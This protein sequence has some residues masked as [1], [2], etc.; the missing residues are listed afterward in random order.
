[1]SNIDQQ[2]DLAKTELKLCQSQMDKYDDISTKIKTWSVTVWLTS[3]GW[4]I[5]SGKKEIFLLN[6]LAIIFFWSLDAANKNYRT[7]YKK[8]RNEIASALNQFNLNSEWPDNFQSPNLP[9][10]N[11]KSTFRQLVEPHIAL[12]YLPLIVVALYFVF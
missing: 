4:A 2:Y 1:M 11:F 3:L 10:H 5:Q 6:I 12:L 8:R 9:A 7:D